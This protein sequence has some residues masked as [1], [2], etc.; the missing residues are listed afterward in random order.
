MNSSVSML[1]MQIC[2]SEFKS[3]IITEKAEH[4]SVVYTPS[5]GGPGGGGG[6]RVAGSESGGSLWLAISLVPGP[7]RYSVSKK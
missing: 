3:R 4:H 1:A 5:T 2:R 7:L 6:D